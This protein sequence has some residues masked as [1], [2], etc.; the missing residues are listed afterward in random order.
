MATR[1]LPRTR[2]V[3][4]SRTQLP[5]IPRTQVPRTQI[6][7]IPPGGERVSRQA[8]AK[9]KRE[10]AALR[11]RVVAAEQTFFDVGTRLNA[12]KKSKAWRLLG[13]ANFK[14]FV[15][16]EIMPYRTAARLMAIAG[17]YDKG[18]AV[19]LGIEKSYQL[20][21]YGKQAGTPAKRLAS[22]DAKIGSSP[23]RRV[24]ELT[25]EQIQGLTAALRLGEARRAIP[26]VSPEDRR[27]AKKFERRFVDVWGVDPVLTIDKKRGVYRLEVPIDV[28]KAQL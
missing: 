20:L 24:S 22:R 25:G 6:P 14:E 5:E 13:Y 27:V 23:P 12:W 28:M 16:A 21:R 18:M 4:Q 3:P 7:R 9:L 17:H 11:K 10:V 2:G 1:R 19:Q 8:R 15:A 26:K